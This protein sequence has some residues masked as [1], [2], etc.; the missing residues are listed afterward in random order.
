MFRIVSLVGLALVV[1][2]LLFVLRNSR[3]AQA[4]IISSMEDEAL[5]AKRKHKGVIVDVA[6][7]PPAGV[8][9]AVIPI[10]SVDELV[11]IADALLKPV[12][13]HAG[14]DKHAYCVIDGGVRY[15]HVLKSQ[16]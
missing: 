5:R 14:A 4:V 10:S 2:A 13:H 15:L 1:F 6:E 12:L 8:R 11:S 16:E 9:E 7:L 3:Q